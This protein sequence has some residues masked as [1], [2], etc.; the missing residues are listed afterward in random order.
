VRLT[1]IVAEEEPGAAELW[2]AVGYER[3]AATA[4]FV[5]NE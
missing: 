3:Q 5:R 4:R 2:T 1:A